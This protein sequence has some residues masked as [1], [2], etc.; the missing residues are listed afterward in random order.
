MDAESPIAQDADA[1]PA[2]GPDRKRLRRVLML[3]A[4][5]AVVIGAAYFYLVGGRYESTEN[6]SLQTGI[7]AI[8]ASVSGKVASIE[9][10]ENQLVRKGDVLFRIN[11][12]TFQTAVG[13]AEAELADARTE[14]GSTQADYQEAESDVHAAEARYS[15][16][17]GEAARQRALL[18][19]GIASRAQYD[20]AVTQA[21][22]AKDAIAAAR[23]KAASLQASLS[24]N[25]GGPVD[26]Q[27]Q[28]RKA[29]SQLEKARIALNDTI[30][31]APR[32]GIVTRVHQLQVGN[33]VTAGRSVFMLTG[34]RFWVQAN[35][36]EN[37]LRYMRVGQPAIVRID[38]FPDHELKAH[39]T[40]FSPGTGNSFSILPA[41]N[42]TGNWV[43]V[44]QRL[45]VEITI[46]EVPAG[47]PLSA[48]LSV[49]AEV[50]TGHKRHL[51]SADTP[52]T[53]PKP[54]VAATQPRPAARP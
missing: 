49:E 24:G 48:G 2:A 54:A 13:E 41:E 28:V 43:K 20:S 51:F 27:P 30:V 10:S 50:D 12:D 38:A 23:A 44:V 6:A 17:Q 1:R 31:R 39:V 33:Y 3:V 11:P 22:T 47:L 25:V 9:V 26:L 14:V 53:V 34:T 46:D 29:A 37:Q 45:P 16:A 21:R 52:P 4:P 19:E 8:S 36:K 32:D 42:A 5:V 40:S 15:F 35:F 18:A 7:V